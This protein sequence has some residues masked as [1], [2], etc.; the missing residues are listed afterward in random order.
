[1]AVINLDFLSGR[2]VNNLPANGGEEGSIPGS[3]RCPRGGHGNPCQYPYLE[4]P[5]MAYGA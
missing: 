1:M 4:N 2:V 5:L 3:G